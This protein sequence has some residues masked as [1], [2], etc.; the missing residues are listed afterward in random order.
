MH[1]LTDVSRE[2][3]DVHPL[4]RGPRP[5]QE[6]DDHEVQLDDDLFHGSLMV[7]FR[8]ALCSL[9]I[10][11]LSLSSPLPLLE[12]SEILNMQEIGS[13]YEKVDGS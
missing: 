3:G 7:T 2:S 8:S 4:Y 13:K 6:E 1:A 9:L 12:L 5:Q 11:L 10:L